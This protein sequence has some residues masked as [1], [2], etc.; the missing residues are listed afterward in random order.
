MRQYPIMMIVVVFCS[1]PMAGQTEK[2]DLFGG[3]SLERI[4]PGC[5]SNYRCGN[6]NS[7][8]TTTSLNGWTASGTA[9]VYKSLGISAQFAGTYDGTAPLSYSTVH[10]HTYQFGPSYA[11][12]WQHA[13]VFAHALFGGVT[14]GSSPDQSLSYTSFLWSV[15]GGLDLKYSSRISFRLAQFDYERQRLPAPLYPFPTISNDG[16]RYSGGIVVKF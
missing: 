3:Y 12:R 13:S 5:G 7:P 11:F 2:F 6:P 9:F 10:R 8:G 16:F 1:V 4:A 14:Q 15:G